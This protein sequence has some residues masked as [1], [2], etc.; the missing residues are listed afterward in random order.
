MNKSGCPVR[1]T[2]AEVPFG[3]PRQRGKLVVLARHSVLSISR[4]IAD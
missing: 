1:S 2:S 3:A 4:P